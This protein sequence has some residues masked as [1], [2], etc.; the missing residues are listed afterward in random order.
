MTMLNDLNS[1]LNAGEVHQSDVL[2]AAAVFAKAQERQIVGLAQGAIGETR[3]FLPSDL[4]P[5]YA[6][7]VQKTFGARAHQLGWSAKPGEDPEPPCSA[8]PSCLSWPHGATTRR[9]AR[10][11]AA[12]DRMAEDP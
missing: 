11:P 6:R 8:P 10:R 2:N 7:F 5:N 3:R 4:L 9:C 12:C 1:L